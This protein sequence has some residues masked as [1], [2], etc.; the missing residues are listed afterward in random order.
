[1][2]VVRLL[3]DT[4]QNVSITGG[5]FPGAGYYGT[6]KGIHTIVMHPSEL[7]GRFFIEA[8]LSLDPQDADWFPILYDENQKPYIEYYDPIDSP[9][10]WTLYGNYTYIRAGLDRSYF[11]PEPDLLS[12]G[13]IL[14]VE[15]STN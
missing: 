11:I 14:K 5:H 6:Q 8:T 10:V 3:D 1:M 7:I 15:M 9:Q 12:V 4:N 2:A 13:R